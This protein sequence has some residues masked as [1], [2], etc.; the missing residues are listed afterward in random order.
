MDPTKDV[1]IK[2]YAPWCGHC[3]AFAPIYEELAKKLKEGGNKFLVLAEMD[4]SNNEVEGVDIHSYPTVKF[5]TKRNKGSPIEF[6]G[7]R[8]EQELLK[9]LEDY[10]SFFVKMK[11]KKENL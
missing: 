5:F 2:Y 3:K 9:F 11:K 1:L 6:K 7:D 4:A 10:S 8:N